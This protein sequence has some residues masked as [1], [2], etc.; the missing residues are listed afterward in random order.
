VRP[1]C[2]HPDVFSIIVGS[3]LAALLSILVGCDR[4][5]PTAQAPP[6]A[7]VTVARP[8][9]QDVVEWD[10][11]SG[12]TEAPDT[13]NVAARVSG[14]L[15]SAPFTE[16]AMV[17]Q[18]DLL[19]VIDPRPFQA[20]LD[21]R[22]AD[23]S[24]AQAQAN[25]SADQL[26]RYTLLLK[27]QSISPQDFENVKSASEQAN[28]ALQAAKAAVESA[29]LDLEW[30]RV[31]API[32]GRVGRKLV[33]PGN[34]VNGGAGQATLLT[35]IE[36]IDPIYCYFEVNEQAVL[37]YQ[38]LVREKRR[39]S[40]RESPMPIVMQLKNEEGFPHQGFIDFV[41]NRIDAGTGTIRVRG[42]FANPDH[43]L[44][45][46]F[47]VRVRVPGSGR[48]S[49]LLVPDAAVG[50][51]QNLR[52]LLLVGADG[53]VDRRTV[54]L[55]ALFGRMRAITQGITDQDRVIINGLQRARPGI[56]VN[57]TEQAIPA[58]WLP[59]IPPDDPTTRQLPATRDVPGTQPA[60][61]AT[62]GAGL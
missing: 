13:A 44:L 22:L 45:P 60:G 48:Y 57:A 25:L 59:A 14:F 12:A 36:S 50:T 46:G 20:T 49:A 47:F 10:E 19:F 30:S 38:K 43:T 26:Q 3:L 8:V 16:G 56:K 39:P 28:A 1:P 29:R 23:V 61:P 31:V 9:R 6:P 58:D 4:K 35:T 21:A 33:T 18:G 5:T 17:K 41:N 11:Y 7:A 15:Q 62:R 42:I 2:R 37:K 40:A 54:T 51:D 53:T 27:Q 34:L 55:G 52:F 32:A 24:K